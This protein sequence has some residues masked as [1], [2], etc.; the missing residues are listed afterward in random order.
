MLLDKSEF[1]GHHI[2]AQIIAVNPKKGGGHE[3]VF[4][5]RLAIK[6]IIKVKFGILALARV[7]LLGVRLDLFEIIVLID[8]N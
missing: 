7:M 1:R 4:D 6:P 8:D 5:L 2:G 3:G